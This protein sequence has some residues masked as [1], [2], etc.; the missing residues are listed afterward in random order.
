MT[1]R[2]RIEP[3][4]AVETTDGRFGTVVEV[5]VDRATGDVRQ[6][7]VEHE[8]SVVLVPAD[9]IVDVVS[10]A[11]VRLRST[12]ADALAHLSGVVSTP[13]LGGQVRVPIHEERLRVGIR[14]FDRGELRVHKTVERVPETIVQPVEREELEIERVRLDRLID[15]PVQTREENGW[16]IVP[17]MEEVLVVKKQLVLTEEVRI[18]TRKVIEQQEVYD[19][20]RREHV[21]IEDATTGASSD[22]PTRTMP[23]GR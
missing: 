17:V 2:T 19:V 14:R 6:L 15:E 13:E 22:V 3:G 11:E 16:L 8:D 10:P 7:L 21:E 9:L 4:A 23:E 20:L 18:R 1:K 12:R 5:L